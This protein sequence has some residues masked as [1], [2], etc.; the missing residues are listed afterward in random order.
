MLISSAAYRNPSL[1]TKVAETQGSR[2]MVVGIDVKRIDGRPVVRIDQGRT[3]VE[4]S[5]ADYSCGVL[6]AGV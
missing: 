6:C 5:P 3:A 1:V 2:V 4:D